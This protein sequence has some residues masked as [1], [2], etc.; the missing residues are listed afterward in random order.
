MA[1][2]VSSSDFRT[3]L[4]RKLLESEVLSEKAPEC[5][6]KLEKIVCEHLKSL[7]VHMNYVE[8]ASTVS[9]Y[10][11]TISRRI[12][13]YNEAAGPMDTIRLIFDSKLHYSLYTFC[14]VLEE[15]VL[16][17]PRDIR[18]LSALHKMIDPN[19]L[20]CDGVDNYSEYKMSIGYDV[21]NV[22]NVS[23]PPDSFRHTECSRFFQKCKT[24][25]S[26]LLFVSV[27]YSSVK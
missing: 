21:K 14:E 7:E 4:R 16:S 10:Y 9:T 5:L 17:E 15:G 20:V 26:K 2:P 12:K 24:Q 22:M 18:Q 11:L 23:L 1:T 6:H 19:W 8:S 27:S 25:K 13:R 3:S